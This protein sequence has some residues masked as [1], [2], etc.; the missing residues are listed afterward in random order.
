MVV[1]FCGL[2]MISAAGVRG[3]G[4]VI[5]SLRVSAFYQHL[6]TVVLVKICSG[7]SAMMISSSAQTY[8]WSDR[9]LISVF[10]SL[11]MRFLT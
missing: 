7:F 11:V 2:P 4:E 3:K 10:T 1:R 5:M 9:G 8:R 6:W